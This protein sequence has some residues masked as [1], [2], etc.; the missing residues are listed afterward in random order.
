MRSLITRR[1]LSTTFQSKPYDLYKLETGPATHAELSREDALGYYRTMMRIR[2][3][4][5][6]ISSL[7]I[8]KQMRGFCHLY[9][10]QEAVGVGIH[11]EML[12]Q[13]TSITSYRCHAWMLLMGATMKEIFAELLAGQTGVSRGKGG[14]MHM[15]T[16]NFYGGNGIVGA[17]ISL[18][19]GIAL[20]HQYK[21]DGGVCVTLMGDGALGQGQ[22]WEVMN[23]AKL[24]NL[25]VLYVIE[26]NFYSMGTPIARHSANTDLYTRGDAV[27]GIRLDGM[28]VLAVRM[29]AKFCFDYIRSGKGPIMMEAVTYR[30]S[31]HSL[32]DPGTTYRTRD[33]VNEVRK[34]QDPIMLLKKKILASQLAT[35][36]ELKKIADEAKHEADTALKEAFKDKEP[37]L[38]EVAYDVYCDYTGKVKMCGHNQYF[39][40]KNT[41]V[42][43]PAT[44]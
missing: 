19:T 24:M 31:G 41:G 33:E 37:D 17:Q 25:P 23:M 21:N 15:Y 5:H 44:K 38:K 14:S 1:L 20:A 40:H 12:P 7:Y 43:R 32:S 16:K 34:T 39:E 4:E 9:S 27:P 13:D 6:D 42:L 36:E 28:D 35:E 22:V 10:G 26:N 3:M 11:A 8:K 29:G 2:K 30:Y 18:G